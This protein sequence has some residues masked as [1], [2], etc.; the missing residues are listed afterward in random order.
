MIIQ[1]FKSAGLVYNS[2]KQGK[3]K[4]TSPGPNTI[5]HARIV[6]KHRDLQ[7]KNPTLTA[8]QISD[9]ITGFFN[10]G[11]DVNAG[12]LRKTFDSLDDPF[13]RK[14]GALP[15]ISEENEAGPSRR[16]HEPPPKPASKIKPAPKSAPPP[17]AIV[18]GLRRSARGRIP[19]RTLCM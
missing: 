6:W 11:S 12:Y 19:S 1:A 5:C 17:P 9:R 4:A 14:G 16:T 8:S 7:H 13:A 15:T 18:T 2:G 3:L 10:H